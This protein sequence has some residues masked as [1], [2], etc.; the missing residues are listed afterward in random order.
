VRLLPP[1][2]SEQLARAEPCTP[3]AARCAARSCAATVL[4][5]S[6]AQWASLVLF[7]LES[8]PVAAL[9]S[10]ESQEEPESQPELLT[11]AQPA[12]VRVAQPVQLAVLWPLSLVAVPLAAQAQKK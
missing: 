4:A 9:A 1:V 11:A 8:V 5:A 10:E 3:G 7:Q 2:R 12:D 6:A